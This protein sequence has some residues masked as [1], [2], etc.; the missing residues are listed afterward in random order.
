MTPTPKIAVPNAAVHITSPGHRLLGWIKGRECV[1]ISTSDMMNEGHYGSGL[2]NV[3]NVCPRA[4]EMLGEVS[5]TLICMDY[6]NILFGNQDL[7][8]SRLV[9]YS[10]VWN[11]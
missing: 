3:R 1:R 10:C 2:V 5:V 11:T 4:P 6:E 7:T 8:H 9:W